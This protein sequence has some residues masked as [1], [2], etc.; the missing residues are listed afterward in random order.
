MS[1]TSGGRIDFGAIHPDTLVGDIDLS[2]QNGEF[3]SIAGLFDGHED[4][5]LREVVSKSFQVKDMGLVGS[6]A[7]VAA[8]MGEIMDEAGGDG[9]LFYLPTTRMNLAMV[10]DGLAPELRRRGLIRE[11]YTGSTLKENLTAF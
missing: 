8:K 2:R 4:K 1:Y 10:S 9:F 5:T 11:E 6:P 3:T 7:T